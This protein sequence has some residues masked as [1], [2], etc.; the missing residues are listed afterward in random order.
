MFPDGQ[1]EGS[2]EGSSNLAASLQALPSI[3]GGCGRSGYPDGADLLSVRAFRLKWRTIWCSGSG[4]FSVSAS[5]SSS[6]LGDF[7]TDQCRQ[8]LGVGFSTYHT[9]ACEQREGKA[10]GTV[11]V[12]LQAQREYTMSHIY[13]RIVALRV[14]GLAYKWI[15]VFFFNQRNIPILG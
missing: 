14:Q 7:Y 6:A 12:R 10:Q 15:C 9:T 1:H 13:F 3:R 11:C 8:V 2:K 4:C 5:S